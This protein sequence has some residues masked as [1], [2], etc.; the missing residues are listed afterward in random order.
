MKGKTLAENCKRKYTTC[1]NLI[2]IRFDTVPFLKKKR[3]KLKEEETSNFY[4]S[5]VKPRSS[6]FLSFPLL[7]PPVAKSSLSSS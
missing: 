4:K 5:K 2:I 6:P 1:H 3:L 7:F